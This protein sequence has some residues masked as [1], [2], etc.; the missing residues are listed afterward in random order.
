MRAC[1]R[2]G[3]ALINRSCLFNRRGAHVSLEA[4]ACIAVV[5]LLYFCRIAVGP[6]FSTLPRCCCK[7]W[8]VALR[9]LMH[10]YLLL[11]TLRRPGLPVWRSALMGLCRHIGYKIRPLCAVIM[12]NAD[13]AQT[14]PWCTS[15][16]RLAQSDLGSSSVLIRCFASIHRAM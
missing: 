15:A 7:D 9:N 2:D 14:L 16:Q 3:R 13:G 6:L 8:Q 10:W 1:G 12:T 4:P 5:S 11:Y